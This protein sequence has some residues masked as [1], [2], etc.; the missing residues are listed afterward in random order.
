MRIPSLLV[1]FIL[2]VPTAGCGGSSTSSGTPVS[3]ADFPARFASAW[4][5]LMKGCCLEAGGTNDPACEA[6]LVAEMTELGNDAVADGA[7]W[8]AGHA[9]QCLDLVRAASCAATDTAKLLALVD[10]CADMWTGTVP[11][12]GACRTY[13]SC[14]RPAPIGNARA[15]ASCANS[16]CVQ[17]VGQ[18]VGAACNNAGMPCDPL[19]GACSAGMCVALPADGAACTGSC[20]LGSRCTGGVCAPLLAAGATCAVNSDC[21]SDKCSGGKCASALAAMDDYCALP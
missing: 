5:A 2:L 4:C 16:V 14:A 18:P 21:A 15:G 17:V 20:R 10:V 8:D 6:G 3:A 1:A 11:P 19:Q 12:G 9:G 7:T 13:E